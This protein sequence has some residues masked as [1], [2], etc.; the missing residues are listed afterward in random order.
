MS[1]TEF[2]AGYLAGLEEALRLLTNN[3]HGRTEVWEN[4][5]EVIRQEL[6]NG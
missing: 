6:N 5:V 2:H 1:D 4:T 3:P